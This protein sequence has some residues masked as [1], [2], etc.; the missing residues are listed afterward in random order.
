VSGCNVVLLT[1]LRAPA[2][3]DHQHAAV[4][5]KVDPIPGSEGVDVE[6]LI[7]AVMAKRD[8]EAQRDHVIDV[9][10]DGLSAD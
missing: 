10:A 7:T 8:L 4:L 5:A 9:W 1:L 6:R 3:Q 2:Q